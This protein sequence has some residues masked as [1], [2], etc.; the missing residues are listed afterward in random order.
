VLSTFLTGKFPTGAE[1]QNPADDGLLTFEGYA[2]WNGTSFA[3]AT[4]SGAIAARIVPGEVTARGALSQLLD[5]PHSV[6]HKYIFPE[7][8]KI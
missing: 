1:P 2:V 3:A 6:V 4:T 7:E 5:D 8:L